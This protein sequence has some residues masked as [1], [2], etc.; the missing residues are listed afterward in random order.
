MR[1]GKHVY[2][3]V[4]NTFLKITSFGKFVSCKNETHGESLLCI[5]T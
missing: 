1:K 3:K 5:L 2:G 4:S